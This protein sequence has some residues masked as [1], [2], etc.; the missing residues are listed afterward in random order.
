MQYYKYEKYQKYINDIP[1]NEYKQGKLIGIGEYNSLEDCESNSIYRWVDNGQVCE[2]YSLYNQEKKQKST[3]NGQ[4]WTDTYE[5]RLGRLIEQ[6]STECGWTLQTRWAKTGQ[7]LCD[8]GSLTE[9][10]V[11]QE[12]QDMGKTWTDTEEHKYELIEVW[13]K[14]CVLA[15]DPIILEIWGSTEYSLPL[16][17][18]LDSIVDNYWTQWEEGGVIYDKENSFTHTYQDNNHHIVKVWGYALKLE[19]L[20]YPYSV[21]SWG[22]Y[23]N[24]K[25]DTSGTLNGVKSDKVNTQWSV[26]NIGEQLNAWADDVNNI[27]RDNREF[28]VHNTKITKLPVDTFADMNT[29]LV[30]VS[31]CPNLTAIPPLKT[32]NI[33]KY[34]GFNKLRAKNCT[35]LTQIPEGL[36]ETYYVKT[37]K[38]YYGH[39]NCIGAFENCTGLTSLPD[40]IDV[41]YAEQMFKGCTGLTDISNCTIISSFTPNM[42]AGC[43]NITTMPAEINNASKEINKSAGLVVR[44]QM[45]CDTKI[46]SVDMSLID[47]SNKHIPEQYLDYGVRSSNIYYNEMFKGCPVNTLSGKMAIIGDTYRAKQCT[48]MFSHTPLTS[49][50]SLFSELPTIPRCDYMFE[51][52]NLQE[53]P[54]D[55][56]NY[57][58]KTTE[59]NLLY[60]FRGSK[61]TKFPIQNDSA[62]WFWPNLY[63]D[64]ILL[65][66]YAFFNCRS[67][68]AQVPLEWGGLVSKIKP[69]ILRAEGTSITI[70]T[71]GIVRGPNENLYKD[72]ATFPLKV[73]ENTI[74]IW[75]TSRWKVSGARYQIV[76]FGSDG[77]ISPE[78]NKTLI[79]YLGTDQGAFKATTQFPLDKLVNVEGVSVDF[80]KSGLN[81]NSVDG[82]FEYNTKLTQI[83]DGLFTKL[84]KLSGADRV[85]YSS[86]IQNVDGLFEGCANLISASSAL[87]QCESLVSA[88]R[89]FKDCTSLNSIDQ[90]F[91][92]SPESKALAVNCNQLFEN[93]GVTSFT[94]NNF[95][96]LSSAVG[97]FRNNSSLTKINTTFTLVGDNVTEMFKDCP[98]LDNAESPFILKLTGTANFT[99][100]WQNCTSLTQ[101]PQVYYEEKWVYPWEVPNAVGT[102]C[103]NGCKALLVNY[104]KQIPDGWK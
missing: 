60:I 64:N 79:V 66:T 65:E 37:D 81:I 18:R 58:L 101:I 46:T 14:D 92:P 31:D 70:N 36:L 43:T 75:T 74:K 47:Y 8:A 50:S 25:I 35:S 41:H 15:M 5:V 23:Y 4:T 100:C 20:D 16:T 42:F 12:S 13:N 52:T 97:M 2:G 53:I 57:Y 56:F 26:L 28:T 24:S 3:D 86:S 99:R 33:P 77:M 49:V 6:Y 82:L 22:S 1:T 44:D 93:T 76:D 87:D 71:S 45:F 88:Q 90:I 29:Y 61:L 48:G 19:D 102:Q 7:T 54:N 38:V 83:P 84:A 51:Y 11:K 78:S 17:M 63:I 103:F 30:D 27:L 62:I 91:G 67:I 21:L 94:L 104:D 69:V 68:E 96:K 55:F 72:S 98:L 9:E 85:L 89:A 39:I 59:E 32:Q 34:F 95:L 10:Y 80:L 73:G 40:L